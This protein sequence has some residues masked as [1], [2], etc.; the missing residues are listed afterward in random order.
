MNC[1]GKDADAKTDSKLA[2]A[3]TK[4]TKNAV[5]VRAAESRQEKGMQLRRSCFEEMEWLKEARALDRDAGE[6]T[7]YLARCL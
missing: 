4:M 6:G 7:V 3:K 1:R 5:V 2:R